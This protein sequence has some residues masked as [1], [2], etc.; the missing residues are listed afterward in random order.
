[1]KRPAIATLVVCLLVWLSAS[2][3]AGAVVFTIEDIGVL[4]GGDGITSIN[5]SNQV[6]GMSDDGNDPPNIW[7]TLWQNGGREVLD[8]LG[9]DS[10]SADDIND[11]GQAVGYSSDPDKKAHA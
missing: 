2:G 8:T 4:D 7:P 10:S 11:A 6:V 3:R 1:M 9:G 5:N